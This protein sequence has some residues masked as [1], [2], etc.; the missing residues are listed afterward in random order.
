MNKGKE[1]IK[2]A[3]GKVKWFNARK[4]YGFIE[5]ENGQDIFVNYRAIIQKEGEYKFLL[6]G[7]KVSFEIED[8]NQG[9]KAVNVI[10]LDI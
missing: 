5:N 6:P 3:S 4:G 2:L 9:P 8:S 10:K 7:E 1:V